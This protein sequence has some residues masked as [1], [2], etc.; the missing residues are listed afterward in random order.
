MQ[1]SIPQ[2]AAD[3]LIIWQSTEW[4]VTAKGFGET[5]WNVCYLSEY[6]WFDAYRSVTPS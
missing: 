6:K 5:S 4:I 2:W 1:Q 3:T